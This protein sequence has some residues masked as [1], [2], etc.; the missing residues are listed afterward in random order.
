MKV[1]KILFFIIVAC[2]LF[3]RVPAMADERLEPSV[4]PGQ[5]C[6]VIEQNIPM[7]VKSYLEHNIDSILAQAAEFGRIVEENPYAEYELEVGRPYVVYYF[8]LCQDGV[9]YYP[10][11]DGSEVKFI[12]GIIETEDG[13]VHELRMKG[14]TVELL[15]AFDYENNDCIFYVCGGVLYAETSEGIVCARRGD[16][17]N[18]YEEQPMLSVGQAFEGTADMP[19]YVVCTPEYIAELSEYTELERDF[20][21][22]SFDEKTE[23]IAEKIDS[24]RAVEYEAV[25]EE[26]IEDTEAVDTNTIELNSSKAAEGENVLKLFN[27]QLQYGYNMCW[28]CTVA[29]IANMLNYSTLHGVDVCY[30]MGIDPNYGGSAYDIQKALAKYGINYNNLCN[31]AVSWNLLKKNIDA[32][33]PV[34][35][36]LRRD[37]E[38][39]HS[40]TMYGYI[41][42]DGKKYMAIWDSNSG[43]YYK[44]EYNQMNVQISDDGKIYSWITTLSYY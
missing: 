7:E 35:I 40:V 41:Y 14:D 17:H 34:A 29:T 20:L 27:P 16:I 18:E 25:W 8:E 43:S 19:E 1:K 6:T 28:A 33:Y 39:A 32:G 13:C 15:N 23:I 9:Y 10:L 42:E 12:L 26:N 11:L 44:T 36:G 4:Q 37:Y 3:V 5:V 22:K 2:M 21:L 31:G 38:M 24:F 30:V